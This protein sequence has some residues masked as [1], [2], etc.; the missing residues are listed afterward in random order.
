MEFLHQSNRLNGHILRESIYFPTFGLPPS[1]PESRGRH[2][3]FPVPRYYHGLDSQWRLEA[4]VRNYQYV[5]S[6]D[7]QCFGHQE[8]FSQIG[9]GGTNQFPYRPSS[10]GSNGGSFPF[11]RLNVHNRNSTRR[12]DPQNAF[13]SDYARFGPHQQHCRHNHHHHGF[14]K[15]QRETVL[16]DIFESSGVTSPAA[17]SVEE[18]TTPPVASSSQTLPHQDSQNQSRQQ[19]SGPEMPD[20]TY[21]WQ[22]R[23]PS[24]SSPGHH[25][26]PS[27]RIQR[28]ETLPSSASST[29]SSTPSQ[30]PSS[31]ASNPRPNSPVSEFLQAIH[32]NN[33]YSHD[34]N[35]NDI[36]YD[37]FDTDLHVDQ[38]RVSHS[39]LHGFPHHQHH[40]H[41]RSHHHHPHHFHQCHQPCPQPGH[42]TNPP[43]PHSQ[44]RN[45]DRHENST[46]SLLSGQRRALRIQQRQQRQIWALRR[47]LERLNRNLG[48]SPRRHSGREAESESESGNEGGIAG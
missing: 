46:I 6:L 34:D 8:V 2:N 24:Q 18:P 5:I 48:E 11:P 19:E 33:N 44:I 4:S 27:P 41:H 9:H 10:P 40:S 30:H 23:R 36:R 39:R 17:Y 7:E 25:N 15:N 14:P 43:R 28:C 16:P 35:S 20:I 31:S 47:E 45:H 22:C 26:C 12:H 37:S 42:N 21:A 13:H 3:S 32:N 38:P 29:I 1:V